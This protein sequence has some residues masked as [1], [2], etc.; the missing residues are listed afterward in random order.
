MTAQI[1]IMA[2]PTSASRM[3]MTENPVLC[4]IEDGVAVVMLNN[5][6]LNL[7]TLEM[8]RRLNET[9][10]RLAEDPDARVMVLT[11]AGGKAFCA[12]SDIK[13]FPEMMAAGAVVPKKLALENEAW[14][15]V[16]DFPKPTIAAVAGLAFGGGLELAVC[17]DLIVAEEGARV[18]LPEIKLG[19]FPGSGG[20]VRVT[21]RIGEGRAKE[22]MFFG[23]PLPVETA[24]AWGLVNRV[25]PKGE[26][27]GTAMEMAR[28]LAAQPSIAIQMCKRSADMAFDV[29]EDR[30]VEASLEMSERVFTTEDCGEGVR[31]FFAKEKPRFRHR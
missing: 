4:T 19:V 8:T 16:D 5:P 22:M 29:P 28:R 26:A 14:S 1:V 11:G 9:V 17:C 10:K 2:F 12:G 27:L 24:L 18:A 13:E 25:A 20:T 23:D 15:R 6:P 7:V 31:A 30:A 3:T 21:R